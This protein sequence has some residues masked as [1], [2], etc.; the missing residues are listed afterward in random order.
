MDSRAWME[1]EERRL[2]NFFSI[3][4][5]DALVQ[6]YSAWFSSNLSFESATNTAAKAAAN[7]KSIHKFL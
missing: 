1:L 6:L 2:A 7:P 4:Y 5:T 3:F